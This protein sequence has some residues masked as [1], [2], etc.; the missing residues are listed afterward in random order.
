MNAGNDFALEYVIIAGGMAE[1]L[2]RKNEYLQ[3][4]RK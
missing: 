2:L 4:G 1:T 3:R